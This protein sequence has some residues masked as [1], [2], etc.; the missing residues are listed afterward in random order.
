MKANKT[1]KF[2]HF[3]FLIFFITSFV[4]TIFFWYFMSCFCAVYPNTQIILI[5]DTLLSFSLS[6]LY[7]FGFCILPT[8]FRMPALRAK[9]KDKI[10]LYKFSQ[11]LSFI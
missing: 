11:L 6:M 9:N 1:K 3:K 2:L 5:K 10:C 8:I 4:L 7:P